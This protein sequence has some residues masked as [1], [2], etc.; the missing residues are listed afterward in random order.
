MAGKTG[1]RVSP[2]RQDD[3]TLEATLREFQ[4][5]DPRIPQFRWKYTAASYDE[6]IALDRCFDI[7]GRNPRERDEDQDLRL[8]LKHI[9]RRFPTRLA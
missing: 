4:T 7:I 3:A 5:M 1:Y 9:D 6:G 2:W 8:G